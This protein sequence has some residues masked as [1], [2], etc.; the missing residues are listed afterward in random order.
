M[1]LLD[2]DILIDVL[3]GYSPALLWLQSLGDQEIG[4]PGFVAME[5]LDGCEN[6]R[7]ADQLLRNLSGVQ[8]F[9]PGE[10]ACDAALAAF[11]KG[12]LSHRLSIFDALIGHC[13]LELNLPLHT[14]NQKHFKA[15][16]GLKTV[17]PYS[18]PHS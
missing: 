13:A 18:K 5:L 8:I 17:Q 4:I 7:E 15:V 9:W 16:P 12:R 14:F 2:T 1:L 10:E 3:R 11:A 6:S